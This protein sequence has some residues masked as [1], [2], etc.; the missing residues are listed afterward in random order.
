[1]DASAEAGG[2]SPPSLET[3]ASLIA[4]YQ[5]TQLVGVFVALRLG[6]ALSDGPRTSADLAALTSTDGRL[7]G[8]CLDALCEAGVVERRGKAYGLGAL[9]Q[10]LHTGEPIPL[11]ALAAHSATT[12]YESWSSLLDVL[13]GDPVGGSL[14]DRGE[15]PSAFDR[16]NDAM[17]TVQRAPVVAACFGWQGVET[18]ADIGGGLGTVVL[19]LLD[20]NPHLRASLVDVPRVARE[21]SRRAEAAG[22]ADRLEV[23]S[24]SF[25]D[26]LPPG[27][28][29]YLLVHVLL[30]WPDEEAVEVLRRCRDAMR[31]GAH[32]LVIEP[33]AG[34]S[35]PNPRLAISTYLLCGGQ[36]RTASEH[37]RLFERAGL[38]L[39]R[40]ARAGA[41]AVL[42][43]T[44]A[45]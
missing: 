13:R 43:A 3:L 39:A 12:G 8:W 27:H 29:V 40:V 31:G 11:E 38:R 41:E 16:A 4:G 1:M 23:H 32:L 18:V 19:R 20:E 7:L 6:A 17:S 2:S 25:F 22:L 30:N 14:Y 35:E 28:D 5:S 9:G 36:L 21:A 26:E 15:A 10:M 42:D 37:V 34:V 44:P 45:R 33:V 24:G